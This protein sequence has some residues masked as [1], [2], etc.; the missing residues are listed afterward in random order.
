MQQALASQKA[1]FLHA[2]AAA[3]D[4]ALEVFVD[5]QSVPWA[6]LQ[7]SL[8]ALQVSQAS[9]SCAE[10]RPSCP[11]VAVAVEDAP[12]VSQQQFRSCAWAAIG[13]VAETPVDA[14]RVP[15]GAHTHL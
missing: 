6:S 3:A 7:V 1:S 12:W 2:F 5:E 14:V 15:V 11:S 10:Q 9:H 4:V 8:Q 13:A